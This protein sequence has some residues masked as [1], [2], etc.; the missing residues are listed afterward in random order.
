MSYS[1][2]ISASYDRYFQNDD[3]DHGILLL[4][5][6]EK[7]AFRGYLRPIIEQLGRLL[8]DTIN[9]YSV[10]ATRV[11]NGSPLPFSPQQLVALAHVAER[12]PTAYVLLPPILLLLSLV[13]QPACITPTTS[14][15]GREITPSALVQ[16]ALGDARRQLDSHARATVFIELFGRTVVG[17]TNPRRCDSLRKSIIRMLTGSRENFINPF[18]AI[19]ESYT[20]HFCPS[21]KTEILAQVQKKQ[22]IIWDLV[23]HIYS[24]VT[25]EELKHMMHSIPSELSRDDFFV[26]Y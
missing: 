11:R 22:K 10:L 21:C 23:P 19:D 1:D 9:N 4:E 13:S 15:R 26:R 25:W 24:L 3:I 16:H 6:L 17:C 20:A 14:Y 2:G 7:Y 18:A 5:L 12:I 8:P